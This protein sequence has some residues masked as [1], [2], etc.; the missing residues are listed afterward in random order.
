M[1]DKKP[2]QDEIQAAVTP[3]ADGSLGLKLSLRTREMYLFFPKGERWLTPRG[4]KVLWR[5]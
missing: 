5:R 3:H 1:E 2:L 4:R